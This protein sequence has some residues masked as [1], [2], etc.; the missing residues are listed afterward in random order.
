VRAFFER[1]FSNGG[2][3]PLEHCAVVDDGRACALEFNVVRWGRTE[4][5][6]QPGVAVYVRGPSGRLAAARIYDDA[7]P[8]LDPQE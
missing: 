2:G 3:I 6:P 5:P 4:L 1:L 8:P 7:E